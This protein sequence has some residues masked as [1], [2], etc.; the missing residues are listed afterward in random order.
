MVDIP[1]FA[2]ILQ[3]GQGLVPNY[4][5]QAFRDA[6]VRL[7][8][9]QEQRLTQA[10]ILDQEKRR[11]EN[12]R[13][14]EFRSAVEQVMLDP[15]PDAIARMAVRFPEKAEEL[16]K[17]YELMDQ[18]ARAKD[19]TQ[20]GEVFAAAQA[21]NYKLAADTLRK[22]VEADKAAGQEDPSDI[23][24]LAALDSGDPIQQRAATGQ[25]GTLLAFTAGPE[26]FSAAYKDLQGDKQSPFIIEYNDRVAQF[27]KDAADRWAAVQ[28]TK[29]IPVNE[30]GRVYNAAD[31]LTGGGGQAS[32]V[33]G[34]VNPSS[35]PATSGRLIPATGQAIE[36]AALGVVPGVN[37]T[38][39]KRSAGHNKAVGGVS[40]SYHLTDQAR[41]FTPPKGMSMGQLH[42]KLKAA[43]P[44]FDVINEGDH[45]HVEPSGHG[46]KPDGPIRVKTIQQA[47]KLAPG[48]IYIT[49]DGRTMQR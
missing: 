15:T 34:G 1:N 47:Q 8:Q 7:A 13:E 35:A 17:G 40:N 49:P 14:N 45:V 23:A 46:V 25:I 18:G 38:S 24:I 41:D 30:G 11:R 22:R 44:G 36:S 26:K 33:S 16:K 12:E 29:L 43:L 39:R 42:G 2:A 21:G 5:D 20:I 48:T 28:D 9:Q 37:V 3:A 10:S 31:F 6:Q 32:G 4:A 19:Q 27:G